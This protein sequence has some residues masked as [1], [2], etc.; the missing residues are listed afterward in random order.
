MADLTLT[1]AGQEFAASWTDANPA[2]RAAIADALPLSGD[3][4][5]S[6]CSGGDARER[7]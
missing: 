2:T 3:A 5:R 7:R 6:V 1:V 4:T